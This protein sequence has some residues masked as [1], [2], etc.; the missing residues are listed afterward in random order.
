MNACGPDLPSDALGGEIARLGTLGADFYHLRAQWNELE[1][2][3]EF[4]D[5]IKF[6]P[7]FVKDNGYDVVQ[8]MLVTVD[9]TIRTMP[10]SVRDLPLDS[11][12]T[13]DAFIALVISLFGDATF[14]SNVDYI[15]LGNEVDAYFSSHPDELDSYGR[16]LSM[17]VATLRSAGV[18]APVGIT[19]TEGSLVPGLS[20]A[21]QMA[22][23]HPDLDFIGVTYYPMEAGFQF[24]DPSTADTDIDDVME[25]TGDARVLWQEI[26]YA[27]ASANNGSDQRQG[28]FIGRAI[29][30]ITQH[31]DRVI[32]INVNWSCDLPMTDCED[33][34]T[35]LY[36]TPPGTPGRDAF[37]GFLCSLGLRRSTTPITNRPAWDVFLD[38]VARR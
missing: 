34:A 12:A 38:A 2:N 11:Q 29:E 5:L 25:A 1:N 31:R 3:Q 4:L 7:G 37:V 15:S 24:R 17:A 19:V 14:A 20:P 8:L 33:L 30:R 27:S 32:G 13:Q 23:E 6:A 36:L 10:P 18:T 22:L 21:A 16:F 9:T 28:D 26:G 35:N